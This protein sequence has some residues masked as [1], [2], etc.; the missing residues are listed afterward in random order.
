MTEPLDKA[1]NMHDFDDDQIELI[2]PEEAEKR[3]LDLIIDLALKAYKGQMDDL[4][5]IEPKNKIKY[6]EVA[7]RF[8]GQAKDARYKR[9]TLILKREQQSKRLRGNDGAGANQDGTVPRDSLYDARDASNNKT[10][11]RV[12]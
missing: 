4:H 1:F 11:R 7:E 5:L 6:L 2:I 3:D 12:K 8:L 9:D 10:L